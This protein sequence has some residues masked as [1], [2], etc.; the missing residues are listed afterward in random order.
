M[1]AQRKIIKFIMSLSPIIVFFNIVLLFITS[2]SFAQVEPAVYPVVE[3]AISTEDAANLASGHERKKIGDIITVRGLGN[4]LGLKEAHGYLW[5]RVEGF[6]KAYFDTLNVWLRET[7]R[8]KIFDKRR[9]WIP[10]SAIRDQF[11]AFDSTL[12]VDLNVI[13][14]PFLPLDTETFMYLEE[15]EQPPL[16]V[17]GLIKDRQTGMFI[18]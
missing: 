18:E 17:S 2:N 1:T 15:A 13:Y 8:F 10:F 9:F 16:H 4:G 14:Q 7:D 12:A 5:L 6:T 11:P 3:I